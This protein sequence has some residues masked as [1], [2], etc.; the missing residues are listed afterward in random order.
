MQ[1]TTGS[2]IR[3]IQLNSL[4][5]HQ[6]QLIFEPGIKTDHFAWKNNKTLGETIRAP[7]YQSLATTIHARYPA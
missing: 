7:R 3:E 6:V 2:S 1:T 4:V 5:F